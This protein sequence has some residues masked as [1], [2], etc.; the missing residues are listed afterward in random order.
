MNSAKIWLKDEKYLVTK[1]Q[2]IFL[3]DIIRNK[4]IAKILQNINENKPSHSHTIYISPIELEILF[5]ELTY[6]ITDAGLDKNSEPN[7]LG[8]KIEALIDVFSKYLT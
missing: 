3:K 7:D 5:D 1:Q 6:L 2:L 8:L 4:K